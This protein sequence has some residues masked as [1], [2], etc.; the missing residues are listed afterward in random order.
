[1]KRNRTQTPR[2]PEDLDVTDYDDAS[3]KILKCLDRHPKSQASSVVIRR[4]TGLPK[5]KVE[6]RIRADGIL[7]RAGLV[8][9]VGYDS[10]TNYAHP[11]KLMALTQ[12]A[13]DAIYHGF[14]DNEANETGQVVLDEKQFLEFEQSLSG[15]EARIERLSETFEQLREQSKQR[16]NTNQN[17]LNFLYYEVAMLREVVSELGASKQVMRRKTEDCRERANNGANLKSEFY[18]GLAEQSQS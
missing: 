5:H 3:I 11:P 15:L 10:D 6:Q 4:E 7:V 12:Y 2:N 14:F 18:S 16:N 9:K 17:N 8:K 1:M 13:R